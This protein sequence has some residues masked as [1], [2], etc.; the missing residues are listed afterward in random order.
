[1]KKILYI[2]DNEVQIK[3]FT[4]SIDKQK[5]EVITETDPT[6]AIEVIKAQKPDLILLDIIM[7]H[8]SGIEILEQ[9]RKDESISDT[10]VIFLTNQTTDEVAKDASKL[11]ALNIWE[12]TVVTP[13]ELALRSGNYLRDGISESKKILLIDDESAMTEMYS[14]KLKHSGFDVYTTNDPKKAMA[15]ALE[16]KPDL[17]LLDIMMPNMDGALV[18]KQIR[19]DQNLAKIPI[20]VLSNAIDLEQANNIK[21][22]GGLAGMWDKSHLLP[23]TLALKVREMLSV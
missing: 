13:T 7:D 10:P 5:F 9:I 11:S 18:L 8:I 6:K 20:V 21:A 23:S 19:S 2:D 17:I 22:V 1:M 4:R 15:K 14:R 16:T 12:K 3:S